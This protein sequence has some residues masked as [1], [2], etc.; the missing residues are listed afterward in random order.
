[1]LMFDGPVSNFAVF[2]CLLYDNAML[3][4]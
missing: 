3:M 1:M 4:L 2:S